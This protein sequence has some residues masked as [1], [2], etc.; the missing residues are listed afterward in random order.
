MI[1]GATESMILELRDLLVQRKQELGQP[2]HKDL[3]NWQIKRVLDAINDELRTH[4]REMPFGLAEA[5]EHYWP[6]FTGQIR[7][8][9]ND[10]GHPASIEPVTQENVHASLLIFPELAKLTFTLGEWILK[11]YQ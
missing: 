2:A 6:A 4:R 9:R 8:S 1:G 7:T 11:N 5:V 10:A 3:Q